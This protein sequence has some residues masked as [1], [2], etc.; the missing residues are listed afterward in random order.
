MTNS[1]FAPLEDWLFS[2]LEH[3]LRTPL[4]AMLN[5]SKMLHDG[6]YGPVNDKQRDRLER[7]LRNSQQVLRR[8][9]LLLDFHRLYQNQLD[10]SEANVPLRAVLDEALAGSPFDNRGRQF[11]VEYNGSLAETELAV[12]LPWTGV[13]LRE[14]LVHAASEAMPDP[15]VWLETKTV[16]NGSRL[17]L[18]VRYNAPPMDT[19]QQG[20]LFTIHNQ[21]GIGLPL[22]LELLQRMGGGIE[23]DSIST[24]HIIAVILP[25]AHA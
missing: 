14:V 20:N 4:N 21:T 22:A 18:E 5:F 12:N 13:A 9:D 23:Y 24:R 7:V 15:T 16:K 8:L 2:Y 10:L 11:Q 19:W 25:V 17:V 6:V 1:E 3:E